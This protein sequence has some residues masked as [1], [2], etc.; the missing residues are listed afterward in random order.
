[1]TLAE[2]RKRRGVEPGESEPHAGEGA[3]ETKHPR[4]LE[5]LQIGVILAII[6]AVEV[7]VYYIGLSETLLV[8]ALIVFSATKFTMVVLWFM[9]LKFDDPLFSTIFVLGFLLALSIFTVAI[10]TLDGKLI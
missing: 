2:Y 9:H 3:H 4:A 1:M 8:I 10:A 5:Y 7:A 6:T